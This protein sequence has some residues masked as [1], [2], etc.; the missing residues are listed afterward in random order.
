[1]ANFYLTIQNLYRLRQNNKNK[2][3][4]NIFF[5]VTDC[6]NV[7]QIGFGTV[8]L[9]SSVTTFGAVATVACETGYTASLSTVQCLSTGKWEAVT[10]NIIGVF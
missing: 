7:H 10:C 6:G 5:T 1:L 9:S 8:K 3:L 2:E 4:L